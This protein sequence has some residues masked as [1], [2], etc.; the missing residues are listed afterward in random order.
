[1][2]EKIPSSQSQEQPNKKQHIIGYRTEWIN[3]RSQ[4]V[5]IYGFIDDDE[6]ED[7][8]TYFLRS[9]DP[10]QRQMNPVSKEEYDAAMKKMKVPPSEE[11]KEGK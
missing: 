5:P 8:Q 1:M 7:P 11:T 10:N 3:G 6:A 2:N 4:D 9:N